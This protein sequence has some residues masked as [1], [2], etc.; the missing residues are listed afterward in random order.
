MDLSHFL[1]CPA[2]DSFYCKIAG[3]D[4]KSMGSREAV[5]ASAMERKS[6][7][8]KRKKQ[9]GLRNLTDCGRTLKS[10][11][12]VYLGSGGCCRPVSTGTVAQEAAGTKKE[13]L[14]A[15]ELIFWPDLSHA[16]LEF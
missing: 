9:R 6:H 8:T 10:K 1:K 12:E 14:V 5:H 3:I 16:G 4:G 7:R 13:D 11:A 2:A 15:L